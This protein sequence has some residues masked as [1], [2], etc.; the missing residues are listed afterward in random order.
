MDPT[1]DRWV[2]EEQARRRPV[3]ARWFD[4]AGACPGPCI[5]HGC[6]WRLVAEEATGSH[7]E[8]AGI[9]QLEGEGSVRGHEE[10]GSRHQTNRIEHGAEASLLM[11]GRV[12]ADVPRSYGNDMLEQ[13]RRARKGLDGSW[14]L[15]GMHGQGLPG[16]ARGRWIFA[17][18][19]RNLL[20]AHLI[21]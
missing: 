10:R 21:A 1:L 14:L 13:N 4:A 17:R 11:S 6:L 20:W 19:W 9:C 2:H 16:H 18:P 3:L 12:R 7:A 15:H 5:Q 8:T